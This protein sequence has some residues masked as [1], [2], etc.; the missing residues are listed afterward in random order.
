[1]RSL[2]FSTRTDP[3]ARSFGDVLIT[4]HRITPP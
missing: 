1:M 4:A 3:L 2:L